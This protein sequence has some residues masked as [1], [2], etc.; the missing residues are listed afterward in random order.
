MALREGERVAVEVSAEWV[1]AH[2]RAPLRLWSRPEL[3]SSART[4][5]AGPGLYAWYFDAHPC[6]GIVGVGTKVEAY[7]LVY[8]GIA[9]S[10]R[11]RLVTHMNGTARRS[12]LRMTLGCLL[13]YSLALQLVPNSGRYNFGDGEP[14]I[15][16]WLDAHARLT[17]VEHPESAR[18]E[19]DVVRAL[20][21]PLN[22][23]HN[24]AH[25][26]YAT[27]G[28]LRAAAIPRRSVAG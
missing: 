27:L 11:Q 15:S 14:R 4:I 10:L 26:H 23:G 13:A 21:P 6:G 17:W 20:R 28:A 5:P 19:G 9:S 8:V 12:T 25:P 18:V 16:E 7:G 1:N 22:R 3:V 2:F 24:A